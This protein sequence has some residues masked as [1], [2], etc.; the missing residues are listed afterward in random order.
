M[1]LDCGNGTH[2]ALPSEWDSL[3]EAKNLACWPY[4]DRGCGMY[5]AT[6]W[7]WS[8]YHGCLTKNLDSDT[9]ISLKYTSAFD[10][11]ELNC[12]LRSP[13]ETWIHSWLNWGGVG[14]RGERGYTL[15]GKCGY[16]LWYLI[17]ELISS[18]SSQIMTGRPGLA[19]WRHTSVGGHTQSKS[20][21]WEGGLQ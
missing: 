3:A 7:E 6:W 19:S 5:E 20:N 10:S 12:R 21:L 17:S 8:V 18:L 13:P 15:P 4:G 2:P 16:A 1:E 14:Q 11:G 9:H